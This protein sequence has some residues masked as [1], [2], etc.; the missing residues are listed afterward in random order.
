MII[1]IA[2]L[3]V[4]VIGIIKGLR[5]GLIVALF[6][7]VAFIAGLAAAL[8]LSVV[9]A[10]KLALHVNPVFKWLPF[11]SFM[12]I[13]FLVSFGVNLVGRIIQKSVETIMLGWINRL[14]GMLLYAALYSFI[15][16]IFLFFAKQV[17]FIKPD[18]I[19][20]SFFYPYIEP[21]GPWIINGLGS[22]IPLFK[23][24]FEKLQEFFGGLS[25]KI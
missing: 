15:F 16:S 11:I 20:S 13:F 22:I 1:D 3:L 14:G 6:S 8:K 17:N 2:Y 12:L 10:A 7:I 24:M 18:T 21:L 19:L 5:R 4:I 9:V 23:D 25:N